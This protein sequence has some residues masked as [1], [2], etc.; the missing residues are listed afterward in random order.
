MAGKS[1]IPFE[2]EYN[3]SLQYYYTR[4]EEN[5][6]WRFDVKRQNGICDKRFERSP[7]TLDPF[8]ENAERKCS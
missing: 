5:S 3:D 6:D 2:K 1:D 8:Y 7:C 4:P